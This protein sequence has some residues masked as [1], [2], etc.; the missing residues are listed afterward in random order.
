MHYLRPV[1]TLIRYSNDSVPDQVVKEGLPDQV[2]KQVI[3][4]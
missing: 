3:I 1:D 4:R 2:L